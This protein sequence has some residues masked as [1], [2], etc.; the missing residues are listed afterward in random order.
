MGHARL[1]RP[2]VAAFALALL[3][4]ACP[5]GDDGAQPDATPAP[6]SPHRSADHQPF[7]LRPS[8]DDDGNLAIRT[9]L[10]LHFADHT[11]D[12]DG[13]PMAMRLRTFSHP[14]DPDVPADPQTRGEAGNWQ[15]SLPAPALWY[16]KPGANQ[17]PGSDPL[18][19]NLRLQIRL[20]NAL[21]EQATATRPDG[22]NANSAEED[23]FP[24]CFH[25]DN[26]TNLHYHGS[27]TDPSQRGDNVLVEVEP[28]EMFF[29]D[30]F[31]GSKQ[32]PG[33]HWY[34]PHKHG[35][36]A[37]QV[38]SGLAGA[39]VIEG[40]YD[41]KGVNEDAQDFVF[42]IQHVKEDVNFPAGSDGPGQLL[43]NGRYN[44][45]VQM[46]PGEIARWRFL[47]A[48][49]NAM[50]FLEFGFSRDGEQRGDADDLPEMRQIAMDG[51]QFRP[52]LYAKGTAV[53]HVDPPDIAPAN[54]AD[55]V[56]R[57]PDAPGTYTL[58]ASPTR[59][60]G[61]HASVDDKAF[62]LVVEGDPVDAD[63]WKMPQTLPPLPEWLA[64]VTEDELTA[65][66]E[67]VFDVRG[68][69]GSQPRFFIDDNQ[70]D[71]ARVDHEMP[72]DGVEEWR[73]VN[74]SP[75]MHPFHIHI[76]PF[77]VVEIHDPNGAGTTRF[78]PD[79]RRWQDTIGLPPA[80]TDADGRV[81][82]DGEGNVAEPGYVVVRQRF[83]DFSGRFVL[84]CHILGHEDRGMMQLLEVAG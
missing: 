63:D 3:T 36:T 43:V 30:F 72:L 16:P 14:L 41:I 37:L 52:E 59:E 31:F 57:A 82:T 9:D 55:F 38:S 19:S 23:V 71:P 15:A 51:V 66:R 73:I 25:G 40:D 61:P 62:T 47:N 7:T 46:R 18:Y 44:P 54:R 4:T 60:L 42:V 65:S 1:R 17:G 12:I 6:G 45:T 2:G 79:E 11:F 76:N 70:F 20:H 5:A 75:I 84:H 21:P 28:G 39:I 50:T 8:P 22:C 27:H 68:T 29:N 48:N 77:E 83:L 10:R 58:I 64:P 56:V 74:R 53:D 69:P 34:H 24:D 26:T 13:K 35:S 78:A 81:V 80:R 33:T 32:S 67:V 49:Q